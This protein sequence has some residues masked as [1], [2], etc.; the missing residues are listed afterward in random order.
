MTIVHVNPLTAQKLCIP[1]VW[2]SNPRVVKVTGGFLM[3]K[4]EFDTLMDTIIAH[5]PGW[6]APIQSLRLESKYHECSLSAAV[7]MYS[8]PTTPPLGHK[9]R[10]ARL[11]SDY[12]HR[13][14]PSMYSHSP[15]RHPQNRRGD[16]LDIPNTNWEYSDGSTE[17]NNVY[18]EDDDEVDG[19]EYGE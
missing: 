2:H 13:V 9:H 14:V 10:S 19:I 4:T 3:D 6:D 16:R 17:Y 11:V 8:H 5:M 12:T 18:E 7:S 1:N 15:T